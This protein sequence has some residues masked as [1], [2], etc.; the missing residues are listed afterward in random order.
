MR[1]PPKPI[2]ALP[3]RMGFSASTG[4]TAVPCRWPG[5]RAA[6]TCT[7]WPGAPRAGC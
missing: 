6:W 5:R 4:P 7:R 2:A 1:P 3:G